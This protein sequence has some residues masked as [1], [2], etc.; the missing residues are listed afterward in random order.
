MFGLSMS[1]P[2][3]LDIFLKHKKVNQEKHISI[4]K[5]FHIKLS[6]E[7]LSENLKITSDKNGSRIRV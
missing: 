7:T 2:F 1:L 6:I 4:Q 3:I 5:N